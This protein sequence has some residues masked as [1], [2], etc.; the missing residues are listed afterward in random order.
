MN[1]I[2]GFR[3][4]KLSNEELIKLVDEKTDEIYVGTDFKF[5]NVLFRSIPANPNEDYDL[6]IGELLLRFKELQS[7]ENKQAG[8]K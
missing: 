4:C 7:N 1:N 2:V 3:L 5:P 8:C 6:L